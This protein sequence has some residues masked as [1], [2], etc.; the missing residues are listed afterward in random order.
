MTQLFKHEAVNQK[1]RPIM[2]MEKN[3]YI[4]VTD[5]DH[6]LDLRDVDHVDICIQINKTHIACMHYD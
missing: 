6:L 5:H 1:L 3:V 4:N 2:P